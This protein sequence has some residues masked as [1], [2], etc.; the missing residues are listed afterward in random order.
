MQQKYFWLKLI[1][2]AV[3]LHV[4]LILLS[5]IEVAVYSLVIEPGHNE[6][7]YMSHANSSGPWVSGI[8]GA[9]FMFLLVRW[10]LKRFSKQQLAYA[11]G[12]PV[13]YHAIDLAL[14]LPS[15]ELQDFVVPFALA[16]AA[17]IGGVITAYFIY[18]DQT[19]LS[20]SKNN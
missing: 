20:N 16:T 7:F 6:A 9:L 19:D 10:F 11:I 8:F 17:K 2:T 13:I 15:A 4:A 5:I 1:G 3:L 14:L 12:L 18:R